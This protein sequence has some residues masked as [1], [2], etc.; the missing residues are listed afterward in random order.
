MLLRKTLDNLSCE[1]AHLIFI[2]NFLSLWLRRFFTSLTF[3]QTRLCRMTE[4]IIYRSWKP[5]DINR[6]SIRFEFLAFLGIRDKRPKNVD[7]AQS[8]C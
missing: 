4:T 2:S 3:R 7:L 1:I 6:P 5:R 8:F